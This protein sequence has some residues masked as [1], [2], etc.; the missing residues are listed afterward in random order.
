MVAFPLVPFSHVKHLKEENKKII[1]N[2]TQ[3]LSEVSQSTQWSSLLIVMLFLYF[4]GQSDIKICSYSVSCHVVLTLSLFFYI[5][6]FVLKL[7][8]S[9]SLAIKK[10]RASDELCWQQQL[11]CVV[12]HYV[13]IKVNVTSLH[14]IGTRNDF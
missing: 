3:S 7:S 13:A 12:A 4:L 8:R 6:Q 2:H 5:S 10:L 11:K 9:F 14:G 1:P